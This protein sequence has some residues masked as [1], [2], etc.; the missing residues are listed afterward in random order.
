MTTDEFPFDQL[1]DEIPFTAILD[2]S[3][4]NVNSHGVHFEM[5]Y[6]DRV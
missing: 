1:S 4:C 5:P 2:G 3:H 6:I